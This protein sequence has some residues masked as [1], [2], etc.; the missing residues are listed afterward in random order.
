M[1][2]GNDD[3]GNPVCYRRSVQ[4]INAQDFF[5]FLDQDSLRYP[6]GGASRLSVPGR[7]AAYPDRLISAFSVCILSGVCAFAASALD[8]SGK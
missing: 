7:M 8:Q 3:L 6:L 5:G 2:F 4:V 1:T